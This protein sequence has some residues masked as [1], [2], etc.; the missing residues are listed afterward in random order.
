MMH[1]T[2]QGIQIQLQGR[3]GAFRLDVALQLPGR[4]V[5][6]LYGGSGSGKT[7]L[8]RCMAGLE[9][10]ARGT[11]MVNGESWQDDAANVFIPAHRRAIGYVFQDAVLFPHLSVR[12]NLEYGLNR[13]SKANRRVPFD[14]AVDLLDIRP[15]LA[16][17]PA[18]L[19]GGEQQRVA[20]ARAL[21]SSPSLLLMDE[22]LASL[23]IPLKR[24][25][26]PYLERLHDELNIPMLYV[27][28]SP[29]ELV[30]LGDYLV[31]LDGGRVTGQGSLTLMLTR[32]DGL[33]R[34]TEEPGAIVEAR[35]ANH[36]AT[37]GLTHLEFQGGHLRVPLGT[38]PVGHRMRCR[39]LPTDVSLALTQACDTSVLNIL[40]ATVRDLKV[41]YDSTQVLVQL[42]IGGTALLARITRYSCERLALRPG[43]PVYAQIKAVAFL[44]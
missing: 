6:V 28:H 40:P 12:C 31:M 15:L 37:E 20:M 21:L 22:P 33:P 11:L 30:K 18:R 1:R 27:T 5:T 4:G 34:F 9:H 25:I 32:L 8:L 13:I 39:I 7:T 23:D 38:L 16:R 41:G 19:S 24:E 36:D 29:D 14:Q 3:F 26:L 43:L 44:D 10:A 2:D 35:V 17:Y 42:D